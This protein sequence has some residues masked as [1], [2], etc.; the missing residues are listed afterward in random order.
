MLGRLEALCNLNGVS[1]DEGRVRRYIRDIAKES[2]SYTHL[3]T[4]LQWSL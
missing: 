1:G 2:V 4:T 3:N